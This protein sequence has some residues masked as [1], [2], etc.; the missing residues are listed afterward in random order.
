MTACLACGCAICF[1]AAENGVHAAVSDLEDCR[2]ALRF[3]R[4]ELRECLTALLCDVKN[5]ASHSVTS[6]GSVVRAE[7]ILS[8]YT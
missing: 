7:A 1:D 8:K 4:D 5:L 2:D 6:R 3:Q